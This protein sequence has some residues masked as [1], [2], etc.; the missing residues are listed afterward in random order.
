ML[1]ISSMSNPI[2]QGWDE[3]ECIDRMAF[4][5]N[6]ICWLALADAPTAGNEVLSTRLKTKSEPGNVR[7]NFT[8]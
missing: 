7:A 4:V 8:S 1:V 3:T 6:S 5:H 2:C